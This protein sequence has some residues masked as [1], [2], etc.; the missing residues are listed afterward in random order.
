[1]SGQTRAPQ[2]VRHPKAVKPPPVPSLLGARATPLPPP[3]HKHEPLAA[4]P[5]PRPVMRVP[6]PCPYLP[7][8]G[9]AVSGA[10]GGGGDPGWLQAGPLSPQ[11]RG[12]ASPA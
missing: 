12:A 7:R 1:M 2:A 4:P 6:R 10:Q 11:L 3:Q 8:P 5:P 9:G